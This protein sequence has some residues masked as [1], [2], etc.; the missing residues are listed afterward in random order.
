MSFTSHNKRVKPTQLEKISRC[1]RFQPRKYFCDQ[2]VIVMDDGKYF[3]FSHSTLTGMN[4]FWTDD[5]E[6]F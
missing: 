3:T 1:C 6:K 5:V 2:K 4:G